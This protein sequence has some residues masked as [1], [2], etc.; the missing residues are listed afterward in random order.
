MAQHSLYQWRVKLATYKP[1]W[2]LFLPLLLSMK[3]D[4]AFA[5]HD[6]APNK[7][8]AWIGAICLA[9]AVF[10]APLSAIADSGKDYLKALEARIAALEAEVNI[11]QGDNKGKELESVKVPTFA[12]P[13]SKYVE[14]LKIRGRI[15]YQFGYV[16]ADSAE[17]YATHELRRVRLG[18]SGK[19]AQDWKF[20]IEMNVLPGGADL[21]NGYIAWAKYDAFQ[22]HFGMYKPRFG[23]E[24][25]TSSNKILTIE[26]SLLSN[27]LATDDI[28]GAWVEGELG[29]VNYNL[30]FYNGEQGVRNTESNANGGG[31]D[32]LYAASLGLNIAKVCSFFDTF[33]IRGDYRHSSGFDNGDSFGFGGYDNS[34]SGSINLEVGRCGLWGEYLFG[35]DSRDDVGGSLQGFTVLPSFYLIPKKLQLVYRYQYAESDYDPIS[36]TGL[37]VPLRSQSRYERRV[38]AD[39]PEDAARLSFFGDEYQAHYVG[40]NYY[41]NGHDLK[42][43]LG[44]EYAELKNPL[45]GVDGN[46]T[47]SVIGAIRFA[48]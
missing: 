46:E 28:T 41:I 42:L 37:N 38:H 12:T 47:L 11:L 20:K 27:Q 48:F 3:R 40:L 44:A 16:N 2:R 23:F 32:F 9:A 45:P 43:M 17:D 14:E 29:I 13:T 5:L 7:G 18:V 4:N 26:R 39:N 8:S 36:G 21:D 1:C 22:P 30:G 15:H 19:L 35:D 34:V 10:F 6:P 25:T 24:D 33:E 31:T